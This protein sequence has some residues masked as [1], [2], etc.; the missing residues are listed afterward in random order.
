MFIPFFKIHQLNIFNIRGSLTLLVIS[1]V[2][3]SC[4]NME[5]DG[6]KDIRT[7]LTGGEQKGSWFTRAPLPTARQEMPLTLFNGKI[8]VPG[9]FNEEASG[10]SLVEVFD[11]SS[12][13]W[14]SIPNLPTPLN[15]L[16][17]VGLNDKLYVIGGYLGSSFIAHNKV[18]EYNFQTEDWNL[19][20]PMFT[21]R[22]AHVSVEYDGKIYAIGG[23]NSSGV[24]SVNEVYDPTSDSW[25][26]LEP[27]PTKQDHLAAA[28]LDSLIYVVGGRNSQFVNQRSLHAYSPA[29]DS[30]H[31]LAD[32]PTARGGLAAAA[33]NGK[34][35]V[36]GGEFFSP[37]SSG[38]F[39]E[40]EE[41]DPVTNTWRSVTSLRTPRHGMSAVTV[42]DTIFVIGGGPVAGFGVTD[43]NQGFTFAPKEN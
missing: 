28:V 15:H 43:V 41:Y 1:V 3:C 35:Y 20:S 27:M 34:L 13:K 11:P 6:P 26:I 38:V 31:T 19:K 5:V 25:T 18:Y 22:G 37:G 36:F 32:M 10:S 12:N 39:K 4:N 17:M 21:S 33:M 30:W 40:N 29:S 23:A 8:Y 16:T 9:G 7:G 24:L 42:A 2:I 14:S